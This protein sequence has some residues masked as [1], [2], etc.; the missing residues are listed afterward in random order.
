MDRPDKKKT[1]TFI[2]SIYIYIDIYTSLKARAM[3]V[4]V[5]TY[6]VTYTYDFKMIF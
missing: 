2:G 3:H 4:V 5:K 6:T 1:H